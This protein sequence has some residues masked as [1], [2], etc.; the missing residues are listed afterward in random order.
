MARRHKYQETKLTGSH[1]GNWL[2]DHPRSH[3]LP[4]KKVDIGARVQE[5]AY[6]TPVAPG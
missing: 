5:S 6:S 4:G 3:A 2:P 1:I